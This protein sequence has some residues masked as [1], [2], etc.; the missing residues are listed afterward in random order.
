MA[1]VSLF[2]IIYIIL[3]TRIR[4]LMQYYYTRTQRLALVLHA[5]A[6][7][8]GSMLARTWYGFISRLSTYSKYQGLVSASNTMELI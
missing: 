7:M 8:G 2:T 3:R 4:V 1:Y 6:G 5:C